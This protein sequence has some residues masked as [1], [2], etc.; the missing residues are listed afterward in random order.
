[1]FP[2][3]AAEAT[4]QH[5]ERELHNERA[6]L[7][8]KEAALATTLEEQ[9]ISPARANTTRCCADDTAFQ[10]G[11][12]ERSLPPRPLCA[13]VSGTCPT[14]VQAVLQQRCKETELEFIKR[15]TESEAA[16]RTELQATRDEGKEQLAAQTQQHKAAMTE[17]AVQL[18]AVSQALDDAKAAAACF[19]ER[20]AAS[21]AGTAQQ[22]A[23][24]LAACQKNAK[25]ADGHGCQSAAECC[26]LQ[27]LT[28]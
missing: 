27:Q 9:V 20:A 18:Q 26:S 7:S 12:T 11:A 14:R 10:P 22:H 16:A 25:G 3:A 15:L 28:V 6:K 5:L 24:Q 21:A 1:M 19:E 13:A 23:Q 2:A 17:Q 8:N 4:T